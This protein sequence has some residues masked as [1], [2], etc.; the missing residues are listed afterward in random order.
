M[1]NWLFSVC[2]SLCEEAGLR[3]YRG[4]EMERVGHLV[5][6]NADGGAQDEDSP[7]LKTLS[8]C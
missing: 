8:R 4:D 5:E 6:Q 3:G 1:K 7:F 2:E